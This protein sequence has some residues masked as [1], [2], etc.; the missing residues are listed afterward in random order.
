MTG[1]PCVLHLFDAGAGWQQRLGASQLMARLPR[2]RFT[3]RAA[4]T[5]GRACGLFGP[6]GTRLELLR[7]H[8]GLDF[9]TAPIIRRYVSAHGVDIVHAWSV[10]S[11][12]AAAQAAG[13]ARVVVELFDPAVSDRRARM[14]RSIQSRP[15]L[16][17][18]C[19]TQ[20]VRRRLVEK[21]IDPELCTVIR[22]GVDFARINA[23]RGVG[24]RERLG[25]DT[26][27]RVFI[28]PEPAARGGG[29]FTA[30]WATAIRSFLH[31]GDRLI[32]PGTSREQARIARLAGQWR[33]SACL[34]CPGDGFAFEELLANADVLLVPSRVEVPTTAMGWA[35]A[36]GVPV[37][38]TA[39]PATTELLVHKGNSLLIKPDA[40]KR[41][42]V[43]LA[44]MLDREDDLRQVK[45]AARGQAYE[46][47]GI[48]RCVDQHAR[49]YENLLEGNR[50]GDGIIDS[51][52]DR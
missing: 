10:P 18:V 13:D 39:L 40:D 17:V 31:T 8:L 33:L 4:A 5:D 6:K 28:A 34:C 45:E 29:Q 22:P 21:G 24:L 32:I 12:V 49:L 44:A 23:A 2:G 35:M 3:C 7:R 9:L 36:A 48:R 1:V 26:A 38:A 14:L 47:F 11:A 15:G 43:K 19:P 27:G 16:G 37:L 20:T 46:T 42:A 41:V 51:A 52:I 25:L 50:P 30:Y